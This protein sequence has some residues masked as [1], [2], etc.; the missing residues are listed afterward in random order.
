LT[1]AAEIDRFVDDAIADLK[2][3]GE[4]AKGALATT[5]AGNG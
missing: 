5:Q 2:A 4:A 1:T 3:M